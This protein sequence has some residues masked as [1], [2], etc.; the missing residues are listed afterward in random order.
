MTYEVFLD[1]VFSLFLVISL[2][3]FSLLFE[4]LFN[5]ECILFGILSAL[6]QHPNSIDFLMHV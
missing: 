6:S 4:L 5:Q 2:Y 3:F 1:L